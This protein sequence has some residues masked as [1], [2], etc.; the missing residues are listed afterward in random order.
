MAFVNALEERVQGSK[1]TPSN[2]SWSCK[3]PKI[4]CWKTNDRN[5]LQFTSIRLF[6]QHSELESSSCLSILAIQ[7]C[8]GFRSSQRER[9]WGLSLQ[10]FYC[11][12][13]GT[14]GLVEQLYCF[15]LIAC[16]SVH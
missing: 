12:V 11:A 4:S 7:T 3:R 15:S 2:T 13:V 8:G 10:C 1:K 9:E 5:T 16:P 6:L 14:V